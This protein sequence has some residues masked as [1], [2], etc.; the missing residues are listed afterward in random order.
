MLS[1]TQ[2]Y[3]TNALAEKM[4]QIQKEAIQNGQSQNSS[5]QVNT[6]PKEKNSYNSETS[7]SVATK[8]PSMLD[9][10]RKISNL[11]KDNDV[12]VVI[13]LSPHQDVMDL[14]ERV[15]CVI[16]KNVYD[17]IPVTGKTINS[18]F[19]MRIPDAGSIGTILTTPAKMY[20]GHVYTKIEISEDK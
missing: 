17:D 5:N 8:T 1:V 16:C 4:A 18:V 13:V 9:L 6:N 14:I 2:E 11:R 15:D 3:L 7:K 12:D 10:Q 20:S 19:T